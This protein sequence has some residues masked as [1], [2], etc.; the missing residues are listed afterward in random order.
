VEKGEGFG[1]SYRLILL[2]GLR[3]AGSVGARNTTVR[4]AEPLT[5][6]AWHE[7]RLAASATSLVLYVD[8]KKSAETS[9]PSG[10]QAAARNDLVIGERFTGRIDEVLISAGP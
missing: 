10:T 9:L 4:S 2:R 8:G 1:G 7:V 5:L 6:N 3:V